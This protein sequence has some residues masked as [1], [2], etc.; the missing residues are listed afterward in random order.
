MPLHLLSC[1]LRMYL[2]THIRE[3]NKY[4]IN[5]KTCIGVLQRNDCW[6]SPDLR[7]MLCDFTS[8]P[9]KSLLSIENSQWVL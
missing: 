7:G 6:S 4:K 8:N 1:I 9:V 3:F 5:N 2:Y